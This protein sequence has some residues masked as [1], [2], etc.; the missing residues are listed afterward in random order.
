MNHRAAGSIDRI[1]TLTGDTFNANVIKGTGPIAVEFMSYGCGY[2]RAIEPFL[3]QVTETLD[4]KEQI[5]RVNID[6]D[7]ELSA[8]F[9]VQGTPTIILFLNGREVGRVEGIQPTLPSVLAVVTQ[10]FNISY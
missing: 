8:G 4:G 7:P 3:Q 1:T 6:A 10:P 2:C 5:F 9:E